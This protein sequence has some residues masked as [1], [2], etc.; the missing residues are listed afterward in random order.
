MGRG[1]GNFERQNPNEVSLGRCRRGLFNQDTKG[2]PGQDRY[3]RMD[4]HG[5]GGHRTFHHAGGPRLMD[6]GGLEIH[7]FETNIRLTTARNH[8]KILSNPIK[9]KRM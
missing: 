1:H 5:H 3:P 2:A 7:Q 6:G 9:S 8:Y 4:P